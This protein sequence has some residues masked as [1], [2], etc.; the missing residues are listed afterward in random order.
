MSNRKRFLLLG[1]ILLLVALLLTFSPTRSGIANAA[2]VTEPSV[3]GIHAAIKYANTHWNCAT[4]ACTTRVKAGD[5]QP[6]FQC[7]EFVARALAAAGFIPKLRSTSPQSAFGHYQPGNGKTYDLLSITPGLA[8]PHIYSLAQFLLD[9]G[10]VKNIHQ[11]TGNAEPGDLVVFNKVIRDK[12]GKIIKIIPEHV[13]LIVAVRKG[14]HTKY[15]T[16]LDLHNS[17]RYHVT[18]KSELG[19]EFPDIGKGWEI[20]HIQSNTP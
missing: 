17:A 9:Y 20:L 14:K 8:G 7:A 19:G 10:Y 16:L 4:A 15:N 2:T 11:S 5:A 12:K 6:D 13:G 3:A 1:T 18:I